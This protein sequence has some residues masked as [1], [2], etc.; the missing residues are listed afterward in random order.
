MTVQFEGTKQLFDLPDDEMIYESVEC[1]SGNN[2]GYKGRLYI[3]E[4]HISFSCNLIGLNTKVR[5]CHK[6]LSADTGH[7]GGEADQEF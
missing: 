4:N 2:L 1:N 3:S 5:R 7:K 6:V